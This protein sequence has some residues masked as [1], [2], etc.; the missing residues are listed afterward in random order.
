M[1]GWKG[2]PYLLP[3]ATALLLA[4]GG[5]LYLGRQ[6]QAAYYVLYAGLIATGSPLII[7]TLRQALRGNFATDA[8]AT[9]A[10]GTAIVLG[11]PFP[12]LII[13][14]MQSGGELLEQRAQRKATRALEELERRAPRTAHRRV[15]GAILDVPVEDLAVGD[16]VLVRAGEVIAADA[17]VKEGRSHVDTAAITGEPMPI[18][19]LPGT[20][21]FSGS[22]NGEAPLIV[23]VLA[24]AAESQYARIVE[25]VRTAQ[26]SK[27]PIQR[28]ADRYAVWFTPLTLAVAALAFLFSGSA[29]RVLAVLVVATPCPLILA[30][31]VAIIGGVNRAARAHVIVRSGA[32][33][34]LLAGVQAV[35]F[36][37]TGTLTTG[38]PQPKQLYVLDNW[39]PATLLPMIAALEQGSSHVLARELVAYALRNG[40]VPNMA[41][42]IE[43]VAGRGVRGIVDGHNV[44][45]G[46]ERFVREEVASSSDQLPA[47]GADALRSYIAVDGKLAGFVEFDDQLRPDLQEL[48][49]GLR[50]AGLRRLVILSGDD[51]QTVQ[52]VARQL[53]VDEAHGDLH[54]ADKVEHVRRVM[55]EVGPTLMIGDG[56]NDAP[57]LAAATVGLAV[58]GG[59]GDIAAE[60]AD[61]ILLGDNLLNVGDTLHI[62]RRAL[63]IAKQSILVGL[64][65]SGVGMAAAAVGWLPPV[66]GALFQEAIDVAVI[67][68]ALRAS[69]GGRADGTRTTTPHPD[70]A[71][72]ATPASPDLA[73]PA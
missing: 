22:L 38:R 40:V 68:N 70:L 53:D 59:S 15:G 9:L 10:I 65:L 51:H 5:V 55:R 24:V 14:L 31:P 42:S 29:D 35:V 33:L 71:R 12:G 8:V 11:Q 64:G 18:T 39:T 52:A 1:F 47:A 41:R 43:E 16:E 63:H 26:A 23:E 48:L 13:V 25:L 32:A 56:T 58:T 20:R 37:K 7:R 2:S 73:R 45:I 49:A 34:E 67:V 6:Q 50:A 57:A 28:L 66:A 60:T 19:A 61:I 72:S 21:L 17:L 46:S 69:A 62:A 44:V 30:T 27:A 3:L 4:A 36:D 54:P